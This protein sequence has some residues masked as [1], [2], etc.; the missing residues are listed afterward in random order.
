MH[1]RLAEWLAE[2]RG[3]AAGAVINAGR[4]ACPCGRSLRSCIPVQYPG[5][6]WCAVLETPPFEGH[7][8]CATTLVDSRQLSRPP[9]NSAKPWMGPQQYTTAIAHAIHE[10]L[11]MSEHA[12]MNEG[13]K[14]AEHGKVEAHAHGASLHE[15][16]KTVHEDQAGVR[17]LVGVRAPWHTA[18]CNGQRQMAFPPR[19]F[20]RLVWCMV[21]ENVRGFDPPR[22][23]ASTRTAD[24]PARPLPA[25]PP[26][27]HAPASHKR[28][29]AQATMQHHASHDK[30]EMSGSRAVKQLHMIQQPR[31]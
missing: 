26:F 5:S 13:S 31:R 12:E 20:V 30:G 4:R 8:R 9:H 23:C 19:T 18:T 2:A 14:K 27:R 15:A 7:G 21:P 10:Q 3:I 29:Q 11:E 22:P 16:H 17:A 1:V 28:A 25:R 24:A 6:S